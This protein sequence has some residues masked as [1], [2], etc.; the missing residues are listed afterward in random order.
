MGKLFEA[1]KILCTAIDHISEFRGYHSK[2]YGSITQ[3]SLGNPV[4]YDLSKKDNARC[5]K[6]I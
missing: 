3:L 6:F 1:F 2:K 5:D 4:N